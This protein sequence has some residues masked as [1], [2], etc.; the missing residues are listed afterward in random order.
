MTSVVPY[1]KVLLRMIS[2]TLYER[3][4]FRA[5][6]RNLEQNLTQ[7]YRYD[8]R[9]KFGFFGKLRMTKCCSA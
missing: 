1:G 4:S 5:Q 8:K 2:V 3:L 9:N 7:S 6:S